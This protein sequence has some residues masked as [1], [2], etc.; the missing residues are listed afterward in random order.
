[1]GWLGTPELQFVATAFGVVVA[2][3]GGYGY[4]RG[5]VSRSE[6]TFILLGA[7][8]LLAYSIGGAATVL[9]LPQFVSNLL[10]G[11]AG[12]SFVALFLYW[13]YRKAESSD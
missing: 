2:A 3:L 12:L 11:L 9:S 10:T 13:A 7:A 6:L 1:M 8:A 5:R 4:S